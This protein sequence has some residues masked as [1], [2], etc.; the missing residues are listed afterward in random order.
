MKRVLIISQHFYPEIGSHANRIKH[1]YIQLKKRDFDVTIFTTEPSYPN[2]KIY[3]GWDF[4]DEP[5][6]N[7]EI[8][9][10]VRI[11]IKNRKYSNSIFNR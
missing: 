9:N 8:D 10:I 3:E 6:L 7:F 4:W 11:G 1:L 2:K 5:S